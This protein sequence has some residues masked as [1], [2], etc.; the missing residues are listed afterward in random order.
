[1]QFLVMGLSLLLVPNRQ[2][3]DRSN[4]LLN[5]VK[6][7]ANEMLILLTVAVQ[8]HISIIF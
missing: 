7:L 2:V 8:Q 3:S 4:L 5:L 6:I 1:M